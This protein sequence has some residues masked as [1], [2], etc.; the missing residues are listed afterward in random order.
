MKNA[1]LSIVYGILALLSVLLFITDL[2]F[3]HRRNRLFLAL[4][5]CVVAASGDCLGAE[6]AAGRAARH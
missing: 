4:F 1:D 2:V 6:G 3:D 5:G